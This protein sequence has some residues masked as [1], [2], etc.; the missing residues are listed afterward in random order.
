[1]KNKNQLPRKI[2]YPEFVNRLGVWP[3]NI[4]L[5]FLY[6]NVVSVV[7]IFLISLKPD[8]TILSPEVVAEKVNGISMICIILTLGLTILY[9]RKFYLFRDVIETENKEVENKEVESA[10]EPE[11]SEEIEQKEDSN[12][13]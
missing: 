5:F 6:S 7:V 8:S 10:T 3:I 2:S 11:V 9:K 12:T 4:G 13:N 1:M